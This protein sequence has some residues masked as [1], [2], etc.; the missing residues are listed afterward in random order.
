MLGVLK[1]RRPAVLPYDQADFYEGVSE[2]SIVAQAIVS[3]PLAALS[4]I[5]L[6]NHR[7]NICPRTEC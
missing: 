4:E 5:R 1:R 2:C 7:L 6:I 3:G